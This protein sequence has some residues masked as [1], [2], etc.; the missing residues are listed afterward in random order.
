M[1]GD[2]NLENETGYY[3]P[4]TPDT[5]VCRL[6]FFHSR[7]ELGTIGANEGMKFLT[8][9]DHNLPRRNV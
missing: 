1:N 2:A 4:M 5:V 8:P 9:T 3:V 7:T 6:S